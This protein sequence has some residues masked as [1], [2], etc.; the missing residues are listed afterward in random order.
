MDEY[1]VVVVGAGPGGYLSAIRLAKLGA[2]VL[3]VDKEGVGGECLN[4]ACIPSK[5]LLNYLLAWVYASKVSELSVEIDIDKL[6]EIRN[7][8]VKELVDGVDYLFKRL[9]VHF[10]NAKVVRIEGHKVYL[11]DGSIVRGEYVVLAT[12]SRPR[13]LPGVPFDGGWV[14]SSRVALSLPRRV[15]TLCVVGAGAAGLEIASIYRLLGSEVYVVEI[16]DRVAPFMDIDVSKRLRGLLG[17]NG[18]HFFLNSRVIGINIMHSRVNVSV[19]SPDGE[20]TLGCDAVVVAIGRAPNIDIEGDVEYLRRD[21]HGF[22]QVDDHQATNIDYIYAVGDVAGPPLLAHKAY[23]DAIV[24][25]EYLFGEGS[26]DRPRVI[27]FVIYS[28]P[29]GFSIGLT[30]DDARERGMDFFVDVYPLA[31]LG[32]AKISGKDMGFVKII[33]DADGHILGIHGVSNK[34]S[35][36]VGIASVLTELGVGV[37]ELGRVMFPHPTYSE[38]YWELAGSAL[39]RGLHIV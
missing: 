9:G 36:L 21:E 30:E 5:T 27:P 20:V 17:R 14:W 1:D 15:N 12:G 13:N 2:R 16:L 7:A 38:A 3:V 23:W 28:Y 32:G 26:V 37:G 24:L 19:S 6:R 4:Y 25:S 18:I 22:I 29:G 31:G 35:E 10:K 11:D 33:R 8:V 39:G 34:V